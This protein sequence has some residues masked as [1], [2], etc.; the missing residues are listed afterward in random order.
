MVRRNFII[1]MDSG[2]YLVRCLRIRENLVNR[3]NCFILLVCFFL[4]FEKEI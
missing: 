3:L 2:G 1:Y 4:F